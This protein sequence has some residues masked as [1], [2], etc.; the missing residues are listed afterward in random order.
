MSTE[1]NGAVASVEVAAPAKLNLALLV[2]PVRPDGFHEIASLD[3]PGDARRPRDCG[4]H[5]GRRADVVCDVGPGAR[6]PRRE[7]R[8]RARGAAGPH[9]R[10][11]HHDRQAR[12]AGGGLGGGSSD[13]AAALLALERLYSLELSPRLRYEVAARRRQRRAVLPVAG[14]PAGHGPR[15]GAQG[16]RAARAPPR[17]RHARPRPQHRG[18]VPLARRG[19]RGDPQG[20]RA[21]GAAPRGAAQR[22]ADVADVAALVANDLEASV[23]ARKAK[24][25]DLLETLRGAGAL[26]AAMTGSGAAVFGVFA[27]EAAAL[28]AREAVAPCPR[29]VRRPICSRPRLVAPPPRAGAV[30]PERARLP[31]R[32][33][34]GGWPPRAPR[35]SGAGA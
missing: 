16:G 24:V 30:R 2:G 32:F 13:A 10:G 26:A 25:G 17:H 29:L 27:G 5:A 7:G 22:A 12:A 34:A 3:A 11:A 28:A 9:V 18:R 20:L 4:A 33:A 23:V 19:R 14:R 8:P 1:T 35:P 6:Q 15:A 31:C 21:A